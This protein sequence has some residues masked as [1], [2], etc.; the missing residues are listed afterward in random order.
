MPLF[1][2]LILPTFTDL[3]KDSQYKGRGYLLNKQEIPVVFVIILCLIEPLAPNSQ[4][5][6]R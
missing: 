2:T 1:P 5:L 4:P 6:P 3:Y